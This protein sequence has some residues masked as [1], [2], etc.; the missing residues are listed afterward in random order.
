MP[1]ISSTQKYLDISEIR[2]DCVILKNGS[3]RAVI[4][5]ASM[6]FGLKSED[7]QVA[8]IRGYIEFLN[9][10]DFP[11]QI[12]IQSRPFNIKP[13]LADLEQL[14]KDQKNELLK[15]QMADYSTF[16]KELVE[17][18]QIMSRR[19]YIVIPY[20]PLGDKKIGFL[21]KVSEL[22]SAV[23]AVKIKKEKFEKYREAL[24]RRVD[25][26][27]SAIELMGLKSAPL[28]TQSLIELFYSSYNP[29][30][31]EVQKLPEINKL[32]LEG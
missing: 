14:R 27:L 25:K 7:E 17:L 26:V 2:N 13:Y 9:T 19:F 32:N 5:A 8:V 31:S 6:N 20:S 28:D 22:F 11:I 4:L 18:G 15:V 23:S 3:F 24:Y 21:S 1:K 16:V 12:I 10:L 30:G 29:A